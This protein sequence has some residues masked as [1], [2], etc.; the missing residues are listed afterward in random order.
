MAKK[1]KQKFRGIGVKHFLNTK[2]KPKIII[3]DSEQ[4][5][6]YPLYVQITAQGQ[7]TRIRS[8]LGSYVSV[9]EFASYQEKYAADLAKEASIIRYQ[10]FQI[11][12]ESGEFDLRWSYAPLGSSYG[13]TQYQFDLFVNSALQSRVDRLLQQFVD[14]TLIPLERIWHRAQ[15]NH[16]PAEKLTDIEFENAIEEYYPDN[17]F[18]QSEDI[19]IH[20]RINLNGD[21]DANFFSLLFSNYLP[22]FGKLRAEFPAEFWD[23]HS[24]VNRIKKDQDIHLITID[25]WFSG[26]FDRLFMATWKDEGAL[27]AIHEGFDTL[28]SGMHSDYQQFLKTHDPATHVPL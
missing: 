19:G 16:L 13:S 4:K 24:Y 8:L 25:D 15:Y 26:E 17:G 12:S 6:S 9:N 14:N 3:T 1:P 5:E 28:R 10:L 27:K 22:G 20:H 23:L 7:N 11:A 21:D 18:L 2:L